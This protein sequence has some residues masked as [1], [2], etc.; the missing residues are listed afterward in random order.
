[1]FLSR[2][3][4]CRAQIA[5]CA[6]FAARLPPTPNDADLSKDTPEGA[7][8]SLARYRI[9][10]VEDEFFVALDMQAMLEANGHSVVGIAVTAEK[11]I[12]L[13]D[14][15]RPN[16]VFMDI[17]L[18]GA[19]DGIDAAHEIRRRFNIP[20]IFVTANS[21]DDTR[22]RAEITRPLGFLEKPFTQHRLQTAL[23]AMRQDAK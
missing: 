9:L 6:I 5:T 15:E 7:D 3:D 22:R 16:V 21:D 19:R 13:A 4:P 23:A 2:L 14:K 10:I 20:S 12:A 1:M 17:R 8:K 11:A 18:A